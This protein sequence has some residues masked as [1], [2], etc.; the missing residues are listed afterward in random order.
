M[1]ITFSIPSLIVMTP[2]DSTMSPI[3]SASLRLSDHSREPLQISSQ[4]I[5]KSSRMANGNLR[6]YIVNTKYTFSTSWKDLPNL[7][8]STVDQF[9][10]AS[11]IKTFYD[12]YYAKPIEL[13]VRGG[14]VT[15][16][17]QAFISDFSL[18]LSKRSLSY[19]DFYDLSLG[20]EQI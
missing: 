5:E 19:Y 6:K 15:D 3:T 20:W 7:T 2:L 12:T 17:Y 14:T 1:A 11:A 4:R 10:G 9:A 16:T 18:T 13:K 8:L